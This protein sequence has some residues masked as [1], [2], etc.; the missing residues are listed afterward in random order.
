VTR[1]GVAGDDFGE[2]GGRAIA[3]ML[4]LN[5]S[6]TYLYF[7]GKVTFCRVSCGGAGDFV[8]ALLHV[9]RKQATKLDRRVHVPYRV[10]WNATPRSSS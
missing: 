8:C 5:S 10:R 2:E 6:I 9:T 7:D 1:F 4:E 3:R